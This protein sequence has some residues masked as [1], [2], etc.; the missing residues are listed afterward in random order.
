MM[1]RAIPWIG[2]AMR[3]GTLDDLPEPPLPP[4]YGWRFFR[5]GDIR[6]WCEIETSAGEFEVPEVGL[7]SFRKYYPTDALLDQRM[8]FLTDNGVPFATATAWYG[9]DGP[10]GGIG[11]LHWVSVDAAHQRR[12]LSYPLVAL[13][14]KRMRELGHTSAYLTTQ[15]ASWP[16]IK[17]Y[18]RFGFVPM[19]RTG[20]DR[21]GW[22]IVSEKTGIDFLN[23]L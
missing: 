8:I 9:E 13:A 3:R 21:A 1:D 20:D 15:T 14:L 17:L 12:G 10:D 7:K 16:A 2:L 5:E 11:R 4:E 6:R 18:H 22:A 19:P 23:L